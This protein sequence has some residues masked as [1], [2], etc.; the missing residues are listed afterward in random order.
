[1]SQSKY[2]FFLLFIL[3]QSCIGDDIIN[4]EVDPIV[5]ITTNVQTIGIGES[6]QFEASYL[7]NIGIEEVIDKMWESSN[8][9]IV[10]INE[11]GLATAKNIGNAV[12]SVTTI[13]AEN[14]LT[15][16]IDIEVGQET[17]MDEASRIGQIRTTSSYALSGAFELITENGNVVINIDDTYKTTSALPGL[18]VYLSN[19]PSTTSGAFEIGAVEVFEGAHSYTLPSEVGINDFNYLL[20]YCKPFNVKVGDGE[21]E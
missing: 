12:I 8:P 16:Q 4:D 1:M 9:D 10:E 18:Y 15:D 6:I 19:N 5:S 17:V 13:S 11:T 20:Y 14:Q 7:N 3:F 21:I 2:M